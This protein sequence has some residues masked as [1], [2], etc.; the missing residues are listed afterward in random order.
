MPRK[1]WAEKAKVLVNDDKK[2]ALEDYERAESSL[3][4]KS[5]RLQ[6]LRLERDA[7]AAKKNTAPVKKKP[8]RR[9]SGPGPWQP[10]I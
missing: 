5:E 6:A 1:T 8:A 2:K 3:R 4:E 7:E 9:K 10:K